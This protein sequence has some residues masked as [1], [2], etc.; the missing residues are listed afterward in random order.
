MKLIL[1]LMLFASVTLFPAPGQCDPNFP[2]AQASPAASASP[3]AVL[4]ALDPSTPTSAGIV[5]VAEP[6]APPA[7]AQDVMVAAQKLP[8]VG[9]IISKALLLLGIVAAILTALAG[10]LISALQAL[11]AMFTWGGLT[12]AANAIVAFQS[13]RF[14]YWLKFFSMF[15]AQKREP[16]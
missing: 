5:A 15:N 7:W 10:F 13:G 8:V 11:K 14:M 12:N 4:A 3:K 9:P 1:A 16:Q 2:V 6:A